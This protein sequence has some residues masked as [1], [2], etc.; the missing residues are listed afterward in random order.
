MKIL[1]VERW[2]RNCPGDMVEVAGDMAHTL[3][4]N[5]V[6]VTVDVGVAA[7]RASL[8]GTTPVAEVATPG[9]EPYLEPDDPDPPIE[10]S[11]LDEKPR[12]KP[13]KGW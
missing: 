13:K 7:I 2:Q 8:A 5:G 6:A 4:G 9:P 10:E 11:E 1:L 12:R 3:I